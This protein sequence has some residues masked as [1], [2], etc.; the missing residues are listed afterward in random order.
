MILFNYSLHLNFM[1]HSR[2]QN[3]GKEEAALQ[4]SALFASFIA[5]FIGGL[6]IK[7]AGF[8]SLF[9]AGSLILFVALIPLFMSKEKHEAIT[10]DKKNL[11][12]DFFKKK[13]LPCNLSFAGYAVESWIGSIIWPLFLLVSGLPAYGMNIPMA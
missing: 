2:Q 12:K 7:L 11:I 4:A 8:S 9:T 6:I 5:P 13:N 10:F 1:Q 3:R